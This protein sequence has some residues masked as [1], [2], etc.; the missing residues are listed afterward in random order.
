MPY[1]SKNPTSY[2]RQIAFIP[3]LILLSCFFINV[4]AVQ[5]VQAKT[6]A[7]SVSAWDTPLT[8][9]EG[10][11]KQKDN[12]Y[13]YFKVTANGDKLIAKRIEGDQQITLTRKGE[14]NFEMPD[15][16]GDELVPVVFSKN[17]AGIIAQVLVGGRQVW[18]RVDKYVPIPVITLSPAQLKAFVG[19]Y[20]LE[21]KNDTYIQITATDAGLVLKQLWNGK[22]VSFAAIAD[23]AFLNKQIGFPLKFT[24]DANGNVVKVVA[25]DKDWWD[26]VAQ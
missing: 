13:A 20:V 2:I 25:F 4:A 1:L 26:K 6:I 16:D 18:L 15:D 7:A 9:F 11:Y 21:Q 5:A 24:K 3:A 14:F 19:K 22:E 23:D 10:I 17:A 12:A 8:A